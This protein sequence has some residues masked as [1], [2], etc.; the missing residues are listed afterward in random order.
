MRKEVLAI[1]LGALASLA[2]CSKVHRVKINQEVSTW[3]CTEVTT[4]TATTMSTSTSTEWTTTTTTTATETT[5][6]EL[7]TTTEPPIT[8]IA[9]E[10]EPV[11]VAATEYFCGGDV[12]YIE[13][14]TT[15]TEDNWSVV[16]YCGHDMGYT[17]P[18]YG[19]SGETLISGYSAACDCLPFGTK[20]LIETNLFTK[21][22][23]IDDCGVGSNNILDLYYY[24]RSEIPSDFLQLGRLNAKITIIE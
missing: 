12:Y 16:W 11:T 5:T 19:A 23:R 20:L 6:T 8:T 24:D 2:S 17:N 14:S 15:I 1:T 21:E 22:I 7:T 4:S 13:P 3:E 10:I 18:P 9:T